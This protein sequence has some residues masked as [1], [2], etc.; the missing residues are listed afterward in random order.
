VAVSVSQINRVRG[1]LGVSRQQLAPAQG[2][3]KKN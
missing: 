1:Q 2:P 3:S